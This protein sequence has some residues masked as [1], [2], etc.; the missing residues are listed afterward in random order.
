MLPGQA[1]YDKKGKK[2][3]YYQYKAWGTFFPYQNKIW[4]NPREFFAKLTEIS[5]IEYKSIREHLLLK[6]EYQKTFTEID[7]TPKE[8]LY[9]P[10]KEPP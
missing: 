5:G 7:Y 1:Y 8:T 9:I 10:V 2:L 6:T 3:G 4:S